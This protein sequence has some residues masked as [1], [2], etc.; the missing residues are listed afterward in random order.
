MALGLAD[1]HKFQIIHRDV[2]SQNIMITPDNQAKLI[3][4]GIAKGP[5]HAT[6]TDPSHFA[7]TLYYAPPEQILEARSVDHRADIYSLGV[8]LYEM[9]TASLPV[10]AREFGT[11]ASKI[12]AGDL[13]PITGVSEPVEQLVTRMLAHRPD[14][15]PASAL[16]V[17]HQ[18]DQIVHTGETTQITIPPLLEEETNP[19]FVVVTTDGRSLPLLHPAVI[20]GRSSPHSSV[21]PDIDLWALGLADARTASREHCVIFHEGD[22][23]FIKD[24][25]SMNGT[26]LNDQPLEPNTQY[27]LTP[28]DQI[29]AGRVLLVFEAAN[30][31]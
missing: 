28:G 24:L 1:I 9:L 31:S 19:Q 13:D 11:I 27:P 21:P 14:Q 10:K 8:V 17:V 23:Y 4:F 12:I 2:K 25:G 15:R 30:Q 18:I 16:D 22:H 20:I 5:D 29:M 3:D 6:L 7:G 26:R